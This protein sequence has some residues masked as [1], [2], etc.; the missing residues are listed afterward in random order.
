MNE[1]LMLHQGNVHVCPC[2]VLPLGLG[3]DNLWQKG[4]D[5]QLLRHSWW[6]NGPVSETLDKITR[7]LVQER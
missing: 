4:N 6:I 5:N 7:H 1:R 2:S 3:S